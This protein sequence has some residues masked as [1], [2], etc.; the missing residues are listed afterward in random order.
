M[1]EKQIYEKLKVALPHHRLTSFQFARVPDYPDV[2]YYQIGPS[3]FPSPGWIELKVV[4]TIK[5]KIGFRK[6]Q[7]T[8]FIE[9]TKSGV[10]VSVLIFCE[11][12]KCYYLILPPNMEVFKQHQTIGEFRHFHITPDLRDFAKYF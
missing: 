9:M 6:G 8:Q 4:P 5:S 7:L 2:Y 11:A 1:T 3:A 12:N 10:R